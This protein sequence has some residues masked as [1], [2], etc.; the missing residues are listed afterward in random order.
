MPETPP[1]RSLAENSKGE[2]YAAKAGNRTRWGKDSIKSRLYT[3]RSITQSYKI[4]LEKVE[5]TRVVYSKKKIL[6]LSIGTYIVNL[7]FRSYFDLPNELPTKKVF[8]VKLYKNNNI[9]Y[10]FCW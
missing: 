5:K 8:Y 3:N 9:K 4:I 6:E 10:Y 1:K 7:N 2:V